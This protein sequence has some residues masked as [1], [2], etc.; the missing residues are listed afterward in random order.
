M[1]F[2]LSLENVLGSPQLCRDVVLDEVR[3]E[4]LLLLVSFRLRALQRLHGRGDVTDDRGERQD[5]DKDHK[6]RVHTFMNVAC[7]DVLWKQA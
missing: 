1:K 7:M 2:G 5:A 4:D 6:N 3:P